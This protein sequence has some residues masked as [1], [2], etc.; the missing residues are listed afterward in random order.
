MA[1][2]WRAVSA[3]NFAEAEKRFRHALEMMP[4]LRIAC[5]WLANTYARSDRMGQAEST[6]KDCQKLF[7]DL[8]R[9]DELLTFFRT[10][11]D[12]DL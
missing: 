4:N 7:P 6:L 1:L 11:A 9:Y 3:K 8:E 12:T 10:R 5:E 2:G